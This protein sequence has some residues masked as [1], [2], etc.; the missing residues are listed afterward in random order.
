MRIG[1]V[2]GTATLL[3][4]VGLTGGCG[5]DEAP[6][7]V[8]TPTESE[9]AS[10]EPSGSATPTETPTETPSDSPTASLTVSAAPSPTASEEPEVDLAQ[11]PETYDEALAHIEAAGVDGSNT[12]SNRF[13]TPGDVVYCVLQH[14]FIPPSCELSVGM[15]KDPPVC[16]NAPSDFVGRVMLSDRGAEPECNTDTIREPGAPVVQ[17]SGVVEAGGVTCAVESIGVTCVDGTRG[18]YITQGDYAVF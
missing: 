1:R 18:F 8:G 14:E 5:D 12:T 7:A 4:I 6:E 3:A 13:S 15:I 11:A 9:S 17:P 2:M 16:G 10:D